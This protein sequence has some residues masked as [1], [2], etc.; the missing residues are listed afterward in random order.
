MIVVAV[1]VIVVVAVAAAIDRYCEPR[2]R[3]CP[4]GYARGGGNAAVAKRLSTFPVAS[5]G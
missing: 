1:A 3:D 5:L 4:S 2:V